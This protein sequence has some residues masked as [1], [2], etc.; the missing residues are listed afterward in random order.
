[1]VIALLGRC[2]ATAG[3]E[4]P[5][6]SRADLKRLLATASKP[7]EYQ[8]LATYFHER[9][10]FFRAKAQAEMTDSAHCIR[11]FMMTPKFPTRAGQTARLYE[12]YSAKADLE[13]KLAVHYDDLLIRNRVKPDRKRY[14]IS[15]TNFRDAGTGQ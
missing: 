9:E 12:Y 5:F 4:V 13:A 10:E 15:V 7:A 6:M 3:D 8:K 1:M 11:N 14:T 2:S